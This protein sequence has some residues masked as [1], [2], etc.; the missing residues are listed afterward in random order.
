MPRLILAAVVIGCLGACAA[1]NVAPGLGSPTPSER[2]PLTDVQAR[3]ERTVRG[4]LGAQ[5]PEEAAGFLAAG[6]RPRLLEW[7]TLLHPRRTISLMAVN[8]DAAVVVIHED[9][10]FSRL[11]GHPGWDG[12]VTYTFGAGGGIAASHFTPMPGKNPSWKPYLEPALPWLR[13]HRGAELAAVYPDGHLAQ[14]A[15]AAKTWARILREWRA[16]TGRPAVD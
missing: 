10:D 13:E 5:S 8:E 12:T 14:T 1:S 9:N 2:V 4:Y 6:Y 16:A 15:D 11:I 3:N 7:D